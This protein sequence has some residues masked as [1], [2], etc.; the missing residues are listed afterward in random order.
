MKYEK[1]TLQLELPLMA[2]CSFDI[3]MNGSNKPH[4]SMPPYTHHRHFVEFHCQNIH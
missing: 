1:I 4:R 2:I 3:L